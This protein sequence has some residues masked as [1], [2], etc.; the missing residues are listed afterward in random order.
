MFLIFMWICW[1]TPKLC[2]YVTM[3][4][5]ISQVTGLFHKTIQIKNLTLRQINNL[6]PF[7]NI[8]LY[9]VWDVGQLDSWEGHGWDNYMEMW[10]A[11]PTFINYLLLIVKN[12]H[13]PILF[14][15]VNGVQKCRWPVLPLAEIKCLQI[16]R[17]KIVFVI[18][19]HIRQ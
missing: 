12:D 10:I 2:G 1:F 13:I 5:V 3:S 11:V 19:T 16:L 17:N 18:M 9:K 4:K 6:Q 8:L 7:L 14:Q 15:T